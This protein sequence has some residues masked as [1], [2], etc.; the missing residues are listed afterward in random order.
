ML[1]Q[2]WVICVDPETAINRLM[3]RNNLTEEQAK[4]RINNQMSNEERIKRSDVVIWNNGDINKTIES[5]HQQMK[6]KLHITID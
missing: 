1:K 2:I 3:K 4:E 6:E 5:I